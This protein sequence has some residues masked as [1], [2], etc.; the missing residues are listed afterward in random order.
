VL[1]SRPDR[2]A[3]RSRGTRREFELVGL[4]RRA[5]SR[6]R[7]L[8]VSGSA[9]VAGRTLREAAVGD[10][11]GVAVLAVRHDGRW[12]VAP[13][14]DQTLSGDDELFAVGRRDALDRFEAVVA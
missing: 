2:L 8:T 7:R 3:V 12:V 13:G 6:F 1:S 4:L 14:G 10:D 5:G 9:D 11:Y